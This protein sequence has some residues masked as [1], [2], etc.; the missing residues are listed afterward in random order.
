MGKGPSGLRGRLARHL[1]STR[2]PFW[3]IDYLLNSTSADLLYFVVAYSKVHIECRLNQLVLDTAASSLPLFGSGDC[4]LGCPG[5]MAYFGQG[6]GET[7]LKKL[8]SYLNERGLTRMVI[9]R[10]DR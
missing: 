10:L 9:I 6:D 4:K 8:I 5:H 2:R 7:I 3:H 1:R